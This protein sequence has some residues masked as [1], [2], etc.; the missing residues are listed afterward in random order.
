MKSDTKSHEERGGSDDAVQQNTQ[1]HVADN[2]GSLAINDCYSAMSVR[3]SVTT[4]RGLHII[5]A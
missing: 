5:A 2:S 3:L 4:R 1:P